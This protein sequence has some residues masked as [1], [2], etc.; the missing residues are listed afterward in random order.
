M[1]AP[2]HR[3]I[4][5]VTDMWNIPRDGYKSIGIWHE[6]YGGYLFPGGDIYSAE[7]VKG[8]DSE[9]FTLFEFEKRLN[10]L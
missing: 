5:I 10:M 2:D 7:D 3:M 6:E 1:P 4:V 8:W 9:S